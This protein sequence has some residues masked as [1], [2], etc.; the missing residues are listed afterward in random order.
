[1]GDYI[2]PGAVHTRFNHC[3][4][5]SYTASQIS[6]KI[7][8]KEEDRQLVMIA[9]LLHDIGHG[10][11][12]HTF[13]D[14]FANKMIRHEDWTPFFLNDYRTDDF[15]KSYNQKNPKYPL[16]PENFQNIAD[17][18]MHRTTKNSLLADI[19]SSQLDAD[20]LDYLLR[21]SH[22]CGV[23]YGQYDFRWMLNCMTIIQSERGS[24][25]GLTHKGIGVVEHYLMARRLMIQNIYQHHKKLAF[26]YFLIKLLS[27]LAEH[28]DTFI[29]FQLIK[30]SRLGKFLGEVNRF[31]SGNKDK[32]TFLENNYATY[33]ELCDYDVFAVIKTL[34]EMREVHPCIEI[35]KRLQTRCMP[36]IIRVNPENA[37]QILTKI[38]D[39]KNK[40]HIADWQLAF[41]TIPHQ[42]YTLSEDPILIMNE[43]NKVKPL[44]EMSMM[45]NALGDQFEEIAFFA[46]DKILFENKALQKIL[47][48]RN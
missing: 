35:A 27:D 39:F 41:I 28:L 7:G 25:L 31:N 20:R 8:L 40:N 19:V 3:L 44:N 15:F 42:S 13:E 47:F 21:D 23:Q 38:E 12:S 22:F 1:M 34:A 48:D 45:I 26:E 5:C 32:K 17:M 16:S 11:F 29:P 10:P 14:L 24:R 18:I 30:D 6:K 4:G 9:C 46:I 36:K 43:N 37:A 2:F 33:K